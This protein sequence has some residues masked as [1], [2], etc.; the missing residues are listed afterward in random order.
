MEESTDYLTKSLIEHY[1]SLVIILDS[2]IEIDKNGFI[3]LP[4]NKIK[5]QMDDI[6]KSI[7]VLDFMH[8]N[9]KDFNTH[10][11]YVNTNIKIFNEDN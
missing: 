3:N 7:S 8:D 4:P 10:D 2:S 9:D 5:K 1:N 6:R 11:M